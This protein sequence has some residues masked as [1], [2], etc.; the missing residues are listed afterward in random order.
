MNKPLYVHLGIV[1]TGSSSVR[2]LI[3]DYCKITSKICSHFPASAEE[4][5]LDDARYLFMECP[6]PYHLETERSCRYFT[7]IRNPVDSVISEYFFYLERKE[8]DLDVTLDD[9]IAALPTSYNKQARWIAAL[10]S[11]DKDLH[12][13]SQ[14]RNMHEDGFYKDVSDSDLLD[15][16][17]KSAA[18]HMAI[19]GLLERMEETAFLLASQMGWQTVPVLRRMNPSVRQNFIKKSKPTDLQISKIKACNCVDEIVYQAVEQNFNVQVQQVMQNSA[20]QFEQYKQY[21]R[22]VDEEFLAKQ[23]NV[24]QKMKN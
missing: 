12:V 4:P 17:Q 5:I 24:I 1:R 2:R 22:Q 23:D 8:I 19:I 18:K 21:C 3:R 16:V 6:Y 20:S 11:N 10:D 9:Y 14:P 7:T 15:Q 13:T